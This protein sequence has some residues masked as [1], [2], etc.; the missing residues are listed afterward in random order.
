MFHDQRELGVSVV[1]VLAV[2]AAGQRAGLAV[3]ALVEAGVDV[4]GLVH[5]AGKE[6][7]ARA[8][9]AAETVVADL[10]DHD[11]LVAALR[12][13]DGVFHVIPAFAPDEAGMG[14]AMVR[15]AVDAGVGRFVFSS[16]Y[17]PSLTSLSNHRAKQPAEQALYDSHLRFTIL[18]PA[19]FMSQ[20]DG[21]VGAARD[22]GV[23]SGPYSADSR[24]SYVDYRD[25]A[26][27]VALAFTTDRLD[28]GTFELSA[29]GMYSRV[30]LAA[31]LTDIV[32]RP[33]RAESTPAALPDSMPAPMREGL[34][35]MLAHYDEHGFHG[36]NDLVLEA[37]LGRRPTGVPDY[38][39]EVAA[40]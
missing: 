4:R 2:G 35:R 10:G 20:L 14:V 40:R 6:R 26:E 21:L 3:R 30:D 27:V 34:M 23:V 39:A 11:A 36:G 31:L 16:V 19:M 38:L 12:G 7:V 1:R 25:V 28:N 15:A 24:M 33:V 13:V 22:K 32:G 8:N 9:G 17:H 5:S 37:I 18:Q 29:P